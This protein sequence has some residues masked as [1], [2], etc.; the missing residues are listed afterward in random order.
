MSSGRRVVSLFVVLATA[1]CGSR[2]DLEA[3]AS[4]PHDGGAHGAADSGTNAGDTGVPDMACLLLGAAIAEV[5][6]GTGATWLWNGGGWAH[7]PSVG[8]PTREN[9]AIAT[10]GG[11]VVV[12]GGASPGTFGGGNLDDTWVWD[13]TGW[14]EP[15]V[16][17]APPA[18]ANAAFAVQ[19]KGAVLF[20]GQ[21]PGAGAAGLGDTWIWDG[22]AWTQRFPAHSPRPRYAAAAASAGSA[23]L[24]FGG[25]T[26][27]QTKM[28]L[29][30]DTWQ[31]DGTDW[32]KIVPPSSPVFR[33]GAMAASFGNGA[34]LFG[35][36]TAAGL[37]SD[38]AGSFCFFND[39]W[40]WDGSTW[41]AA[42]LSG[43]SPPARAFGSAG[44]LRT[45]FVVFGGESPT[46]GNMDLSDTWT[47]DGST[48]T[49]WPKPGPTGLG[50]SGALGC[51]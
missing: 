40:V 21:G 32:T 7:D 34:V 36:L 25:L 5:D 39:T 19:G 6:G 2:T 8:P 47:W 24:L 49:E 31:W 17:A 22:T 43:G 33:A 11:K 27:L 41:T 26:G 38:C 45:S 50:A 12:F 1:A 4:P 44:R 18:R 51:Y 13:G 37:T 30:P 42:A 10:L 14:T 28:E 3:L 46:P 23:V 9:P 20:G 29:L 35:G 16:Q 15:H 48:W